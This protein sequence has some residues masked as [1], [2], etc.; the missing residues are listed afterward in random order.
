MK[1]SEELENH[2][3]H[4]MTQELCDEVDDAFR[5]TNYQDGQIDELRSEIAGYRI[6]LGLDRA[7]SPGAGEM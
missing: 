2:M 5:M 1:P 4:G 3:R 6:L 7:A